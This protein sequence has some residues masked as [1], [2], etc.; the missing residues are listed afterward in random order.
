GLMADFG[1]DMSDAE[2]ILL[3]DIIYIE[4]DE[5]GGI[6]A[7]S[8]PGAALIAVYRYLKAQGCRWLF[9]GVDGEWIPVVE[10]LKAVTYRKLADHRYR[11]QCN[12]GA[13]FQQNMMETIDFTPKIGLNVYM[14]EFTNPNYY[15]HYYD[16]TS[17]PAREAEYLSPE[18]RLQWKRQCEA[19]IAKRGLQF[20]DMGHGWTCEPFGIEGVAKP[21]VPEDAYQ[22]LAL[23]EGKR[24]LYRGM[25]PYNTNFCMSNPEARKIVVDNIVNYSRIHTNVDYLHVWLADSWNNHCECDECKKKT[26]SDWYVILMNELDEALTAAGLPTRIVFICYVDTSWP[27]QTEAIKN[28][29]RFSLLVAPISRDYTFSA[30]EDVSDV[31]Y[32]PYKRNENVLFPDVNQ[33]IKVGK[34]WQDICGVRAFLYE[35][36]FYIFQFHDLSTLAFAKVVY[37]DIVNYKKNGLNGLVNDCSQRSFFPNGFAFYLYGQVQFDTSLKFEDLV[38]DYF[39]HAYGEDWREVLAIFEKLGKAVPHKYL[40]RKM[41]Y[42]PNISK[43]YNPSVAEGLRSVPTIT[44]EALP[45]IE[46]HRKMPYRPQVLSYKLLRYYMEYCDGIANCFAIKCFGAGEEAKKAFD[47]FL[48]EFGKYEKEIE[49]YYDQYMMAMCFNVSLKSKERSIVENDMSIASH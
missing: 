39:S 31:T 48:A 13:E 5:Q 10:G 14:L 44:K 34:E 42:N 37:D 41:S 18:T 8:N 24:D 26:P 32:P 21:D 17:N 46:A 49:T 12:E 23:C 33:Y 22:Y 30:K 1:L 4:A 45:F 27:P 35:Y 40:S 3:D 28:P 19:E 20:H 9:P 29:K 43:V 38:E 11:G 36:H 47:K 16:R 6:I 2:D 15:A 7:G 25:H